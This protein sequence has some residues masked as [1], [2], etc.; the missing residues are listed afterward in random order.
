VVVVQSHIPYPRLDHVFGAVESVGFEEMCNAS[1]ETFHHAVGFGRSGLG[2]PVFYPE[3]LAQLIEP[4]FPAGLA[5]SM[6]AI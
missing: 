2:P 1:I 6:A 5:P 3:G 4:M